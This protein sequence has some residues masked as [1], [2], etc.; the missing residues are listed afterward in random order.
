MRKVVIRLG[1]TQKLIGSF[2]TY[3]VVLGLAACSGG[4]DSSDSVVIEGNLP[5]A[6]VQRTVNVAGNP[7]DGVFNNGNGDL[8]IRGVSSPSATD[9]NITHSYTHHSN[10]AWT[11]DVSDPEVSYDAERLLFAMRCSSTASVAADPGCTNT[12]NIWE[13]D[14]ASGSMTRVITDDVV[15]DMGNDVDP[16]YL[17][18]GD[19]VFSSDRQQ[20]SSDAT[21]AGQPGYRYLDEYEREVSVVLHVLKRATQEIEQISYNQSHDRNPIVLSSG[22]VLYSRWDHVGGR[23]QFSLFKTKPDGTGMFIEYGAHSGVVAFL[24]PREMPDGRLLSDAMPLSG[25]SEGGALMV[26]DVKNCSENNDCD[27]G[28]SQG[29]TQPTLQA[30]NFGRGLSNF[31]R[32]T[33][34]YPLWDGTNRA[35]VTWTPCRVQTAS[36]IKLCSR[37]TPAEL[38][39]LDD[40]DGGVP[41]YGVYMFSMDDKTLR[42]VV[43]SPDPDN[44]MV[45]DPVAILSRTPPNSIQSTGLNDDLKNRNMGILNVKSV[46]DTDNQN[47]MNAA[48]L[49]AGESIPTVGGEADIARMKDPANPDYLSR[50][51]R[52]V[53][54]T[55]SVPTPQ[56]MG[57]MRELIGET[58]LEMQQIVGITDVQPDGSFQVEIPADTPVTIAVL[59]AEGRAFQTHTNWVQ[60]RPGETRSCNGCHSPRRG[61]P[62]VIAQGTVGNHPNTTLAGVGQPVDTMA[63]AMAG[64][65]GFN[66]ILNLK[67]DIEYTDVLASSGMPP[68]PCVSIRYTGN[69]D[70]ATGNP[71]PANDLTTSVPQNG[72]INYPEH[73]QPIWD[74]ACISCHDGTDPSVHDLSSTTSGTGRLVSYDSLLIGDIKLDANGLP[75][76][77]ID[78]GEV[79][80][81]R[82]PA[83]VVTGRASL[84]SRSAH[85]IEVIY[86]QELRANGDA[87]DPQTLP[88][89]DH[90]GFL[91]TAERRLVTEWVDVGAQYFNSFFDSNGNPRGVTSLDEGDFNNIVHPI[92]MSRCASCHQ[93]FGTVNGSPDPNDPLPGFVG[94]R[95]VLTGNQSGDFN[96]TLSVVNNVCDPSLSQLLSRPAS[97]G[98]S[99][100]HPPVDPAAPVPQAI[101]PTTDQDYQ[102]IFAWIAAGQAFATCP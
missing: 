78:D 8:F 69:I 66:S 2:V 38:A 89:L 46:Y 9:T 35:L 64:D 100:T 65:P 37:L 95:F 52:F 88:A 40:M 94:N 31:G 82:F 98:V 43:L 28:A 27:Q 96:V 24:H 32:F 77:T 86:D 39:A 92:L 57:G 10:G 23:N 101:L 41:A 21:Q 26:I 61:D 14:I 84:S 85:L 34:P 58:E 74:K 47:R 53:R 16:V 54:F 29:Q 93:P 60:V 25:T 55:K 102:D 18:N 13:Y 68:T 49:V 20:K 6:F 67:S 4:S 91:N 83:D 81:E 45:T 44:I 1:K 59:D 72:V 63:E 3:G 30:I 73:I 56:G 42:P 12:W 71:D 80:V 19:I 76:V 15:A 48:V 51:A 36:G 87:D 79:E 75:I 5:I 22:E 50:V 90:S 7:T 62:I 97:T 70:C 11:G 17:P 33:T 99:P